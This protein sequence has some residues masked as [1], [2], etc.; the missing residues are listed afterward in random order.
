MK[1]GKRFAPG[2]VIGLSIFIC[3]T[4]V[5]ANP[6]DSQAAA[7]SI[8]H[9]FADGATDGFQPY[10]GGPALSGST[11]YGMTQGGRQ[12]PGEYQYFGSLYKINT[13]ATG[14]QILHDFAS[15]TD[16]TSPR[17]GLTL[18]GATLYG[19]TAYGGGFNGGTVFKI[20]TD[21]GGYQVLKR[22]AMGDEE[23]IP[24]G[25]PV[26]SGSTLYGVHSSSGLGAPFFGAIFAMDLDGG[27]YRLLYEFAGKPGDGAAAPITRF[28]TISPVIPATGDTLMAPSPWWAPS[29]TA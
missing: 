13:D 24:Y 18:S 3:L 27:N 12:S 28:C 23:C 22:F 8:L 26:I 25:A 21:G 5:L 16:G 4:G 14:Y 20:N 2:L 11:L 1:T 9:D 6:S 19:C 10:Y 29:S 15:G 17:G 7:Y